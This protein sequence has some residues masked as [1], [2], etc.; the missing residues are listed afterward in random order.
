MRG[1]KNDKMAT[2]GRTVI[3]EA[4]FLQT[5][6]ATARGTEEDHAFIG[7]GSAA[8]VTLP[9]A[10]IPKT[11]RFYKYARIQILRTTSS[12]AAGLNFEYEEVL[13]GDGTYTTILPANVIPNGAEC[14][15]WYEPLS[16]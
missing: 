15:I 14:V 16:V 4:G 2:R 1:W 6:S 13:N 3:L 9:E 11:T 10:Y 12:D 5:G 8:A 7:N